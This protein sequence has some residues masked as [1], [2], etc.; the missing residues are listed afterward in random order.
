MITFKCRVL[1]L[2][3]IYIKSETASRLG[4]TLL[5]PLLSLIRTSSSALV[6]RK[7]C[8]LVRSYSHLCRGEKLPKF[9]SPDHVFDIM[10]LVHEEAGKPASNAHANACSQ[11]SLLLARILVLCDKSYLRHAF[12][13]YAKT[14]E[15][16]TLDAGCRFKVGFFVDWVNWC[17]TV[18]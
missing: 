16:A 6:S 3:D 10:R 18:K 4:P 15:R 2:L 7:G 8:D 13:L 12:E 14:Q 5:I 9:A 1:E 17:Y 11:A